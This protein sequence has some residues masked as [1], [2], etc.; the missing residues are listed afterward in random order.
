MMN[1]RE[2]DL[3][4][5]LEQLGI[6]GEDAARIAADIGAGDRLMDRY[7]GVQVDA[8][9]LERVEAGAIRVGALADGRE[10]V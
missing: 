8:V 5:T 9:V 6:D 4:Q 10:I 3:E 2:K 7:G 1:K